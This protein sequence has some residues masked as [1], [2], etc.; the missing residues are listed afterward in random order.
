ML[1]KFVSRN[2]IESSADPLSAM[3]ISKLEYEDEH[4]DGRNCSR[5][6]RPFQFR[7]TIA[8]LGKAIRER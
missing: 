5:Y 1:G 8:T 6:F 2:I 4:T 7:I 3:I